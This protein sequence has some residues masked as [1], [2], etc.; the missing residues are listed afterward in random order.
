MCIRDRIQSDLAGEALDPASPS[1]N[2]RAGVIFL[3]RLLADAGGD[4][5]TAVA[6]YY[7]GAASVATEGIFGETQQYVDNVMALRS[8]FGG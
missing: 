2:V 4:E 3:G 8:R 5:V 7:Q 6:G 1:D